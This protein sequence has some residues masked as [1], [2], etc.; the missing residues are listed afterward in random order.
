[1]NA[2]EDGP[3][4]DDVADVAGPDGLKDLAAALAELAPDSGPDTVLPEE[5][6]GADGSFDTAGCSL[7]I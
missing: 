2:G 6:P 7:I 4:A 1:M 5:C 3:G